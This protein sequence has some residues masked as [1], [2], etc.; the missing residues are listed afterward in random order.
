MSDR[1][2]RS[3]D[4]CGGIDDHPRH[5]YLAGPDELD[6]NQAA[7]EAVWTTEGLS[8]QDAHRIAK[9][10]EDTSIMQKHMDCCR[11]AGCPDGT[12]D[13]MPAEQHDLR[14]YKLVEA[15]TGE[16]VK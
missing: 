3:C 13:A 14:G 6:V 10:L 11:A 16:K 1:P 2:L 7:L 4:E 8:A 9:E 12:C 15:I 5:V